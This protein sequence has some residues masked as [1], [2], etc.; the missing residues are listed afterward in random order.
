M[1]LNVVQENDLAAGAVNAEDQAWLVM[2]SD[3]EVGQG[4][5]G[6]F[7]K[8]LEDVLHVFVS[9]CLQMLGQDECT[10]CTRLQKRWCQ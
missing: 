8:E 5:V 4:R 2:K 3:A 10:C 9:P 6:R 1:D 7:R